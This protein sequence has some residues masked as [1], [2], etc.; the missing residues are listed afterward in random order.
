MIRMQMQQ[1]TATGTPAARTND[2]RTSDRRTNDRGEAPARYDNI[3]RMLIAGMWRLG[4][5]GKV[6]QDRDPYSGETLMEIALA[7]AQD[8]DD[9]YVAAE[10]AQPAWAAVLPQERRAVLE[11]AALIVRRRKD[12]IV[13]W[14]IHEAG[15][16]RTKANIEWQ[17]AEG[18]L[19]EAASYPFNTD[20]RL[21]PASVRGKDSH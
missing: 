7:N 13:D 18:C 21:L 20:G 10:R 15:S 3:G 17:L 14:L 4:S 1:N 8:L 9:A 6:S 16:T 19:L 11:R 2:R 5:S 12:E